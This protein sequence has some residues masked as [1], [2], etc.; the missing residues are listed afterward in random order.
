MTRICIISDSSVNAV[1]SGWPLVE[2]QYPDCDITYFAAGRDNM[3][4]LEVSDGRLISSDPHCTQR[5]K[6]SS[7]G[8]DAITDDYDWFL[9][10]ALGFNLNFI[11]HFSMQ[12]C[13]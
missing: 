4:S 5:M 13:G 10:F 11:L 3:R 8:L 7:D 9:I 12:S 2:D 1:K 6:R